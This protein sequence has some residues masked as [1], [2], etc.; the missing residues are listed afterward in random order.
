MAKILSSPATLVSPLVKGLQGTNPDF[1]KVIATPKHFA[2]HSG[3]ESDRHRF[4]ATPTAHDLWET[5]LPAFRA[6]IVEAKAGSI[7]CAYNAIDGFPACANHELL[8]Q[9]LRQDWGF[10]GFVTSDCGAVDD[11]FEA[12]AHHTSADKATAAADGIKTGTDT[13]CGTT[14]LALGEA[15]KRGLVT[16]AEIDVSLKRLFRARFQL[17]LFDPADR[18]PYNSVPFSGSWLSRAPHAGSGDRTQIHGTSQEQRRCTATE[19]EPSHNC[20]CR[21]KRSIA[22]GA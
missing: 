5:Y 22:L 18:V 8:D 3:P 17:G 11:F 1:F 12:K 14:Y 21:T 13:N 10:K 20:R 2:V 19:G 6:T 15:V 16:E 4:N 7:M 9:I